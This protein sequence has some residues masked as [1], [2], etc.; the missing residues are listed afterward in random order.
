MS[1][2]EELLNQR[3]KSDKKQPRSGRQF[4]VAAVNMQLYAA[5]V[6]RSIW[7]SLKRKYGRI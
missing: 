5:T 7:M 2:A 1:E 3:A 6:N 4:G